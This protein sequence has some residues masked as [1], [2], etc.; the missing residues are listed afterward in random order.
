MT[1]SIIDTCI[2]FALA[3]TLL[4]AVHVEAS[5]GEAEAAAG[6]GANSDAGNNGNAG[7]LD[8]NSPDV[9]AYA[10]GVA[11]LAATLP[12]HVRAFEKNNLQAQ[13]GNSSV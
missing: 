7:N 3:I 11:R 13:N 10:E 8:P 12:Y 1:M 2:Y 4:R 5:H 9:T 6:A